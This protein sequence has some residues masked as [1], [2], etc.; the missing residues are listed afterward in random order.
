MVIRRPTVQRVPPLGSAE[1]DDARV[2][3]VG[4]PRLVD[5]EVQDADLIVVGLGVVPGVHYTAAVGCEPSLPRI[6][7][8]D[9]RAVGQTVQ[10]A[11]GEVANG[12][13]PVV[14]LG[15]PSPIR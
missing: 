2:T 12:E 13:V 7:A 5:R 6:G 4:R 11:G 14:V 1:V 9:F 3:R 8:R 15:D 10:N